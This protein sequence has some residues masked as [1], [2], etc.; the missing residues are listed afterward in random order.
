M[1]APPPGPKAPSFRCSQAPRA[2]VQ[3]ASVVHRFSRQR[4]LGQSPLTAQSCPSLTPPSQSPKAPVEVSRQKPQNTRCLVPDGTAVL[5]DVPVVRRNGTDESPTLTRVETVQS[6][7]V[8][9][10]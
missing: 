7:L 1:L 2:S 4:P 8:G 3:S 10:C 5:V 9:Y 6:W